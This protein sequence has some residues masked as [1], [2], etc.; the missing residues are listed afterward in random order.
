[1]RE[2]KN[3]KSLSCDNLVHMVFPEKSVK[4]LRF[5]NEDSDHIYIQIP[6]LVSI[7]S[8]TQVKWN[9]HSWLPWHQLV[10]RTPLHLYG[11]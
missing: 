1:M 8:L 7:Q 6:F 3:L 11:M 5:L 2:K 9:V 4:H 10:A